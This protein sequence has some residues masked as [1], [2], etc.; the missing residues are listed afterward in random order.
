MQ[1][2]LFVAPH[3]STGGQP[4]YLLKKIEALKNVFVVH[5]IEF[6]QISDKFTVQRDK[7]QALVGDNFY[8][9]REDKSELIEIV[10]KLNPDIVHLEEHPECFWYSYDPKPFEWLY[11]PDRTYKLIETCHNSTY[12]VKTKKFL[13]DKFIFVSEGQAKRY[14][15]LNIPYDVVEYPIDKQ[16]RMF[17]KQEARQKLNMSIDIKQV[18]TVGLFTAGKNQGH[19]FKIAKDMKFPANFN[20]IGNQ[21]ENFKKYWGPLMV[22]KPTNCVVW[23]ERSDVEVF[24]QACDAVVFPSTL[25]TNP[26]VVREALAWELPVLMYDLPIYDGAY[27]NNPLITFF[28]KDASLHPAQVKTIIQAV[29]NE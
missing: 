27:S 25:E 26:L 28:D 7:I 8:T 4:Q 16:I 9:L 10:K 14:K 17:T 20:F 11:R 29:H 22:Y 15:N 24:Y 6:S 1:T 23:G 18:L 13:P 2:L 5:V 21:A 19:V 3:L 12:D